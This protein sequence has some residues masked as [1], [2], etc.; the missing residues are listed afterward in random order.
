MV[1]RRAQNA[2]SA[3]AGKALRLLLLLAL[4]GAAVVSVAGQ[5]KSIGGKEHD[6]NILGV[7]IGMTVPEAL[8][9]VFVNANRK[10]GQEKPDARRQEGQDKKDVRVLYNDLKLGK[11]QILFA[12]GKWVKE[13]VLDYSVR[14]LFDEL[15]L[16]P[17]GD[18]RIALGGLRYDDRY[19]IV[20]TE[21]TE[22]KRQRIWYRDEKN[23]L[24]FSE[25][26]QFISGRRPD[27]PTIESKQIVRKVI[28]LSPG[29]E[30]KFAAK[31]AQQ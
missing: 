19:T 18:I 2:A 29:D 31:M 26:I 4:S 5:A 13:I 17:S 9:A 20:F 12:D 3:R 7:K 24:G 14:P 25:R 23:A 22:A 27:D 11:L 6:D 8:Q 28:S 21:E 30:A 1:I 16:A 15:R 10:P